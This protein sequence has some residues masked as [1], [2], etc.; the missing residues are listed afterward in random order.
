[1]FKMKKTVAIVMVVA[2]MAGMGTTVFADSSDRDFYFAV[3]NSHDGT[4]AEQ[5]DNDSSIYCKI[6]ETDYNYGQLSCYVK[7][8][9]NN[10]SST[11]NC[12]YGGNS[13]II[14]F[15]K[16]TMIRN[17]V[18]ENGYSKARLTFKNRISSD[19][20]YIGGVWSPDSVNEPGSVTI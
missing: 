6:N 19:G 16:S 20:Y 5:K 1:M 15:H 8:W 3:T 18:Y 11:S 13:R 14:T 7:A 4:S 2:M 9:G 17:T 10:G 12:D